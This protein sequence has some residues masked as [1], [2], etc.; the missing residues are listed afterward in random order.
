MWLSIQLETTSLS[1][2]SKQHTES[3]SQ[4]LNEKKIIKYLIW[5]HFAYDNQYIV[6]IHRKF[7][8]TDQFHSFNFDKIEFMVMKND[9]SMMW[10]RL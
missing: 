7:I 9:I 8:A 4:Y 2:L 5:T 6:S 10:L 1:R 3:E